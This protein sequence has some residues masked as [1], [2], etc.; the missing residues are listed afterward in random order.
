VTLFLKPMRSP[1]AAVP[2]IDRYGAVSV[3]GLTIAKAALAVLSGPVRTEDTGD[4]LFIADRILAGR[5]WLGPQPWGDVAVPPLF[6]RPIGY[7]ALLAGARALF[8]ADALPAVI[9]L[10][11]G[12]ATL[13]LALVY[14]VLQPLVGPAWAV[15]ALLT[16]AMAGALFDL[17]LLTDSLYASLVTIVLF[18]ILGR[19]VER[20]RVTVMTG[21]ALGLLWG[22]S[23]LLRDAGLYF[24]ALPL[25]AIL[26]V[27]ADQP[28]RERLAAAAALAASVV[29]V[30]AGYSA[31]NW[32]RSGV[33]FFSIAGELNWLWP[34]FSVEARGYAHP[35]AGDDIVS[36]LWRGLGLGTDFPAQAALIHA[37]HE[38]YGLTPTELQ[39]LAFR[40]FLATVLEYPGAFL[41]NTLTNVNYAGLAR[42]LFD[43][44]WDASE[45]LRWTGL[46]PQRLAPGIGLRDIRQA[47]VAGD[48][49]SL[50]AVLGALLVTMSAMLLLTVALVGTLVRAVLA[51]RG[52]PRAGNPRAVALSVFACLASLAVVGAHALVHF[53]VRYALPAVPLLAAA[54]AL[55]CAWLPCAWLRRAPR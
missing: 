6:F 37:L 35:F 41:L 5:D 30:A 34:V 1:A 20:R 7:P 46:V 18:A 44:L 13:A 15:F 24:T 49:A 16:T 45:F 53:E 21:A 55:T 14:R 36:S 9:A 17:A 12:L 39:A 32:Y 4:Y 31:W 54:T 2:A 3:A 26:A 50:A 48:A 42:F 10:Q 8:G 43:P 40:K 33:L 27:P 23:L 51:A 52:E 47:W 25:A 22:A 11:I 38:R 29:V 28:W 19:A